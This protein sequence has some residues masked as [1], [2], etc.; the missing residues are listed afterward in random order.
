MAISSG[1]GPHRAWLTVSGQTFP[2]LNGSANQTTTKKSASFSATIVLTPATEAL[3]AGLGDNDASVSVQTNGAQATL[4]AGEIDSVRNDYIA[5]TIAVTGRCKSAKL[6]EKKTSEKWLNKK[7]TEVVQDLASRVGLSVDMG[8]FDA[9][10]AGRFIQLDWAKVTDNVSYASVLHR[11]AEALG[12]RWWVDAK[13]VLHMQPLGSPK[14]VYT[15]NYR[16]NPKSADVL[17]LEICRN[18]PAGK[19]LT[20]KVHSFHPGQKRNYAGTYTIGGNGSSV[21]YGFHVPGHSQDHVNAHAKH[22]AKEI[23]KHEIQLSARM[24]GDPTIDIAMGLQLS[25]TAYAQTFEMDEIS[26]SFGMR[27]HTMHISAKSAKAGR[28]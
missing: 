22:K 5:G 24:I 15:I 27:G 21:I 19:P 10:K 11:A 6:H 12:A 7:H 13:G 1:F 16:D 8:S 28:S 4:V 9:L 18:I 14:G 25:G 3:F 2:V 20:V 17:K 26:H 23:A